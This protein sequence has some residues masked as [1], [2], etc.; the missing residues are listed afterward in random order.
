MG[1]GVGGGVV[2]NGKV[3]N[4]AQGIMARGPIFWTRQ[5]VPC[6]CGKN[7]RVETL[8]SGTGLQQFYQSLAGTLY[9][10]PEIVQ[11]Y[12]QGGDEAANATIERMIHQFGRAICDR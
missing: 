3:L 10:P 1:T 7:G 4:G 12:H 5:A 2:V 9:T 8:L 11:R 6:Y